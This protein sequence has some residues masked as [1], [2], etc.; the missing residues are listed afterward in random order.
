MADAESR[1]WRYRI[2]AG[3]AALA[4]M[5]VAGGTAY[6]AIGQETHQQQSADGKP[7]DKHD[8]YVGSDTGPQK[9]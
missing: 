7:G 3:A 8:T 2:L 1:A 6:A 4:L 5:G 9:S